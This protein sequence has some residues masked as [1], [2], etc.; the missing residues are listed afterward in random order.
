MEL[1]SFFDVGPVFVN[2]LVE[3]WGSSPYI[4]QVA[5]AFGQIYN[6]LRLTI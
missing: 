6:K 1:E 2:H 5:G 4:L 3:F